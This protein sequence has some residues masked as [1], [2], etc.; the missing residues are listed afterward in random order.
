MVMLLLV[1]VF[2]KQKKAYEMLISDW[3]SD[4]CSSDLA[5]P[6]RRR[7]LPERPRACR[8]QPART[9]RRGAD[10]RHVPPHFGADGGQRP[11]RHP[12]SENGSRRGIA[13]W[14]DGRCAT[15]GRGPCLA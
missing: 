7:A 6:A 4:V 13:G 8:L 12:A 9:A 11:W 14:D 10:A 3:S 5:A 1:I 2:F 15:T